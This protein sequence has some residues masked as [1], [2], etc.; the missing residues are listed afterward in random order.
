[1]CASA[2]TRQKAPKTRISTGG[3]HLS[4]HAI[5]IR[6]KPYVTRLLQNKEV[7]NEHTQHK[8]ATK[9]MA[10]DSTATTRKPNS[11]TQEPSVRAMKVGTRKGNR[12]A[13]TSATENAQQ[14]STAD[15]ID[16]PCCTTLSRKGNR[17]QQKAGGARDRVPERTVL[18]TADE[19]REAR[20]IG[21]TREPHCMW[22]KFR[23]LD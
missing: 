18:A 14:V 5:D 3:G 9:A 20:K 23:K 4:R 22:L 17:V 11:Q 16:V 21:A 7:L 19:D 13:T 1:M 8:Q 15:A 12:R 2:G 6:A 10:K